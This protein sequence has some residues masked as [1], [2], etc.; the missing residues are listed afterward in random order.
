MV[1]ENDLDELDIQTWS[2]VA[3][4]FRGADLLLG[5]GFSVSITPRL[6]YGSL[7]ERFLEECSLESQNIFTRFETSNFELILQKL[8]DARDVNQIFGIRAERIERAI[9]DLKDGLIRTIEDVH[10]RWAETDEQ[11]LEQIA[12]R[13]NPERRTRS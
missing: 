10:P 8:S 12:Q 13:L 4:D 9:D 2:A 5:N 7:F 3:A 11:Q 1:T 6:H